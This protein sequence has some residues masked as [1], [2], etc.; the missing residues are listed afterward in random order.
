M[1][2]HAILTSHMGVRS[3]HCGCGCG[4][5]DWCG[6]AALRTAQSE[7]RLNFVALRYLDFVVPGI[8]EDLKFNEPENIYE[9]NSALLLLVFVDRVS[10]SGDRKNRDHVM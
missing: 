10:R 2:A 6:A 4:C 3:P 8:A 5:C 9:P 7:D 1:R